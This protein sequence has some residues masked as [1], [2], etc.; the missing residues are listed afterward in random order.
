MQQVQQMQHEWLCFFSVVRYVPDPVRDEP[1]NIGVLVLCPD[2][3]FG[4]S[5]ISLRRTGINEGTLQHRFMHSFLQGY[6]ST[7]PGDMNQDSPILSTQSSAR[8]YLSSLH[9]NSAN[10]LQFTP[11]TAALGEPSTLL[12][13]LY[14]QYVSPRRVP[15]HER[16]KQS[17]QR[18]AISLRHALIP[19]G[20]SEW[21]HTKPRVQVA[22]ANYHFDLGIRDGR[23]Y[24]ALD[25]LTFRA[26]NIQQTEQRGAW[27]SHVWRRVADE[28][29]AQAIVLVD[30]PMTRQGPLE[31]HFKRVTEWVQDVGVQ[32]RQ[33]QEIGTVAQDIA[34]RLGGEAARHSD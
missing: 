2:R 23:L 7:L 11:P 3:H 26:Q 14:R 30:S 1:R 33:I 18:A 8:Q 19:L 21:V 17:I 15:G 10:L 12:N 24:Y 5:K 32:V 9:E 4:G 27:Y 31:D 16:E 13:Q 29:G 6:Q 22:G 25:L 34:V 20:K 28:T